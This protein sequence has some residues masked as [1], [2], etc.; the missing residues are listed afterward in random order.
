MVRC[1]HC[2]WVSSTD[3]HLYL[4]PL[5][6][7]VHSVVSDW[8]LILYCKTGLLVDNPHESCRPITSEYWKRHREKI[9]YSEAVW[10]IDL[11]HLKKKWKCPEWFVSL[12]YSEMLGYEST[13]M[14]SI[15]SSKIKL[16]TSR[17]LNPIPHGGGWNPPPPSQFF[18]MLLKAL[19][20][21]VPRLSDF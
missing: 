21:P 10:F 6:T 9:S 16:L 18:K 1:T 7:T 19:C 20:K 11:C 13:E 5:C 3:V 17:L 15:L 4:S 8:H 14:R 2:A 12:K